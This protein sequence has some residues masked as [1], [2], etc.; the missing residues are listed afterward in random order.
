MDSS[1]ISLDKKL[2]LLNNE[3]EVTKWADTLPVGVCSGCFHRICRCEK[4]R[5]VKSLDE[6]ELESR[7]EKK[8]RRNNKYYYKNKHS[9]SEQRRLRY[10]ENKTTSKPIF[11]ILSDNDHNQVPILDILD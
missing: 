9:I 8:R 6:A 10:L 7:L 5:E 11:D 2:F 3:K 1:V 4:I